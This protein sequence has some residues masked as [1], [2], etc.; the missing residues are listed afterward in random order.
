MRTTG[1]ED[2]EGWRAAG[3]TRGSCAGRWRITTRRWRWGLRS[4]P[5]RSAASTCCPRASCRP[6]TRGRTLLAIELPPGIAHGRDRGRDR[7]ASRASIRAR[8]EVKS[9]F[10]NG[11]RV[12]GSRRGG[13]QGHARH[14]S[15]AQGQ[16]QAEPG[17]DQAGDRPQPRRRARHPLLVPAGQR[18]APVRSW[19]SR[20][21]MP[22][23]SRTRPPS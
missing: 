13:A 8:P 20:A 3:P 16:A 9:V 21:A 22:P 12:M 6:R 23:P 14:Q 19:W 17:Q 7:R 18:P 5:A 4:S 11:G 15:G 2:K 1:H 10:V